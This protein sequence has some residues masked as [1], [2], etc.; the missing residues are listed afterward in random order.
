[1]DINKGGRPRVSRVLEKAYT[2]KKSYNKAYQTEFR[3][4]FTVN[5]SQEK[6]VDII[7]AIESIAGGNR[8]KAVKILLRAGIE[9]L[10]NNS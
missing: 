4:V 6:D 5:L 3:Y 1:M 9:Q 10:K 7:E 2:D 8:Q